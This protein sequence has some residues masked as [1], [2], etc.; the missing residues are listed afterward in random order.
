ML[1]LLVIELGRMLT[2]DAGTRTTSPKQRRRRTTPRRTKR[3]RR[4][5]QKKKPQITRRPGLP[6]SSPKLIPPL[7]LL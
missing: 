3:R 5:P 4:N 1:D 7:S 2:R 6:T